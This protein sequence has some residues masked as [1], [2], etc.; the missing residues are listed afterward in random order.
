[1]AVMTGGTTPAVAVK[2]KNDMKKAGGG[3]INKTKNSSNRERGSVTKSIERIAASIE[4]GSRGGREDFQSFMMMRKMEWD[5]AEKRRRRQEREEARR[6]REEARRE[7]EEMEDRRDR[8]LER[9]LQ[10]Q[11]QMMMQMMMI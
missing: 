4:E 1:M 7:R 5:Q 3:K 10:Q 11:N 9:Q 8:R 6:E 2:N